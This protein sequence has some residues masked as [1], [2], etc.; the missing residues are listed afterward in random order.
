M[1]KGIPMDSVMKVTLTR[2]FPFVSCRE[3]SHLSEQL[4]TAV[5]WEVFFFFF[6]LA[7][8]NSSH[9]PLTHPPPPKENIYSVICI[10]SHPSALRY[11]A[12]FSHFSVLIYSGAIGVCTVSLFEG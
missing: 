12:I 6:L 8:A 2:S 9:T 10:E 11:S 3:M 1:V 5:F 7:R 4:Q